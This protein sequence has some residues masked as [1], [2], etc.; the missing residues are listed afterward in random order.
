MGVHKKSKKPPAAIVKM[1]YNHNSDWMA[2]KKLSPL[3]EHV[4][5]LNSTFKFSN[6]LNV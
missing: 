4:S 2:K 5:E 1:L 6:I 3:P